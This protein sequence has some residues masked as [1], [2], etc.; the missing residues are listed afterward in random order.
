M[1]R[2]HL[3]HQSWEQGALPHY[4]FATNLIFDVDT[5][6]RPYLLIP[7]LPRFPDANWTKMQ[8]NQASN[9]KIE[10][11]FTWDPL[12]GIDSLWHPRRVNV[13]SHARVKEVEFEGH[14]ALPRWLFSNMQSPTMREKHN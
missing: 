6:C 14:R 12:G 10:H 4:H 3:S 2:S 9:G 8:M 11:T 1:M 13:L 5:L 7:K